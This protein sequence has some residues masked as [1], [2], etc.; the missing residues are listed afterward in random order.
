MA[1][2]PKGSRGEVRLDGSLADGTSTVTVEAEDVALLRG[3]GTAAVGLSGK[4][5]VSAAPGA[6][7]SGSVR[8]AT[9]EGAPIPLG[10]GVEVEDAVG[11]WDEDGIALGGKLRVQTKNGPFEAQVDGSFVSTSEWKLEVTQTAPFVLTES[12]TLSGVHGL[13]GRTPDAESGAFA[14]SLSG[15]V[16]GWDPSPQLTG[17]KVTGR[18]TN[19]CAE[20]AKGCKPGP[21]RLA[22]EVAGQAR[23][24]GQT[25]P[26]EGEAEVNLKTLA[27]RFSAGARLAEFG[28]AALRLTGVELRMSNEGPRWCTAP[29]ASASAAG[30]PV[31]T[32]PPTCPPP[33]AKPPRPTTLPANSPPTRSSPSRSAATGASSASRSAPRPS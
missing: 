25:I 2:A 28:P 24:L 5:E 14:I 12:V 32:P 9:D 3:T 22:M 30:T 11:T 1:R 31:A 20:D 10:G 19:V 7:L 17:V 8:L 18:L 23:V 26:W 16:S 6:G 21:V 29:G 33:K 27:L 4:G 15:T 13:L